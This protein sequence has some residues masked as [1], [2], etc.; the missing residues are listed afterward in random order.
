MSEILNNNRIMYIF[1]YLLTWVSGIIVYIL[2]ADRDRNLKFHAVQAILL[3]LVITVISIL[4][5]FLFFPV[6]IIA[7]LFTFL[8]YIYGL[9]VGYKAYT[10]VNV[11]MP[12]IGDIAK[13]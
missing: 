13:Q 9:Y 4:S 8:L 11:I 12:V 3:G 10:G 1:A 2:Y 6:S 7:N 5:F